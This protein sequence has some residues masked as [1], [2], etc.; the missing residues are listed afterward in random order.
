VDDCTRLAGDFGR[1]RHT[2]DLGAFAGRQLPAVSSYQWPQMAV[3]PLHHGLPRSSK[4]SQANHALALAPLYIY[5]LYA[6]I[7]IGIL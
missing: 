2:V 5:T 7:T 6:R 3:D 1:F 4:S